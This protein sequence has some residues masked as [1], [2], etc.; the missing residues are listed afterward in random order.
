MQ[1]LLM[2]ELNRLTVEEYKQK[3]KLPI[4]VVLDNVRSL[5]NVGS[6]FRS[7]D[8]FRV[9][10]LYLCGITGTPPHREIHKTALGS[11]ESV[12]WKYFESTNQAITELKGRNYYIVA[13]EQTHNSIV[14]DQLRLDKPTAFVF[15][16]EVEGIDEQVITQCDEC[17]E[18]PQAGT[19][20]SLNIA[21]CTGIVIWQAFR[22]LQPKL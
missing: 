14:L 4:V 16:N 7:S 18:I 12:D 5:S 9:G 13:V 3:E 1:K 21:V 8:A 20:H 17:V 10:A 22:L 6:I 2:H 19:K 15:G 11:T